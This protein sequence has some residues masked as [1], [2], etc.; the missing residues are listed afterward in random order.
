MPLVRHS[1]HLPPHE[2]RLS[3]GLERVKHHNALPHSLMIIFI[4]E[5]H[6]TLYATVH[7]SSVAQVLIINMLTRKGRRCFSTTESLLFNNK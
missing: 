6:P 4:L 5:T 1:F 7:C 3:G 2:M